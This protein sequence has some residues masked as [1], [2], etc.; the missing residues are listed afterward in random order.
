MTLLYAYNDFQPHYNFILHHVLLSPLYLLV[1]FSVLSQCAILLLHFRFAAQA[2]K[3][4]E[5]HHPA[6]D[7]QRE[8]N[9]RFTCSSTACRETTTGRYSWKCFA[10]VPSQLGQARTPGNIITLSCMHTLTRAHKHARACKR[11]TC[12]GSE[13]C[14]NYSPGGVGRRGGVAS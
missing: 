3:R 12:E 6:R 5:K 2:S 14:Q 7:S 1:I 9:S 10:N 11:C 13:L 4:C 8:S